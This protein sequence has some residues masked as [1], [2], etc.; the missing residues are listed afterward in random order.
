[1]GKCFLATE[2][3]VSIKEKDQLLFKLV[4]KRGF[5][6]VVMATAPDISMAHCV[7]ADLEMKGGI[8][9]AFKKLCHGFEELKK[10]ERRVGHVAV[11][12]RNESSF[13]YHLVT[14][15]NWWDAAT[16]ASMR[17]CLEYLREHC[18]LNGVDKLVV[19]R[20]GTGEDRLDWVFVK[21]IFEDVFKDTDLS[22]TA[23]STR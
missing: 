2:S 9:P 20:L 23:Y 13:I 6:K 3:G 10:Q 22:V 16:P 8:T 17:S 5:T 21:Q 4:E 12:K 1:M 14:R 11:S 18:L 15:Q 19:P 7:S